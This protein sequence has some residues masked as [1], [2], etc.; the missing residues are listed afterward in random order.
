M[1]NAIV[2]WLASA[3]MVWGQVSYNFSNFAGQH[4]SAGSADGTGSEAKF[5]YPQGVAVDNAGNVYVGDS[6]NHTI[7]KVNPKGVV[8]T[9]AGS[10]GI[11]GSAD[12]TGRAARFNYADGVAVDSAGIVYVAD[13]NNCTIRIVSLAGVVT[14]LAGLA[15]SSGSADGIGGSARFNFPN[16]VAVDGAGNVFVADSGNQ[17]IRK[18]TPMGV[19]TTLA[20]SPGI[21]GSADGTGR[22]ALFNDPWGVAVD[23]AGNV[24]VAD[25]SNHTIRK[26]TPMGVVTTFA[27]RPGVVGYADGMGSAARFSQP[28]GVAVDSVGN[29]FVADSFNGMI[30]KVTPIGVVTTLAGTSVGLNY[31][32]SLAVDG[33]GNLYVADFHNN[34][35][36]K[37]TPLSFTVSIGWNNG[38]PQLEIIGTLGKSYTLEY[39]PTMP[40]DNNWQVL[41]NLTLTTSPLY[42]IDS[43]SNSATQRFYRLREEAVLPLIAPTITTQPISQTAAENAK[44]SF[45]VVAD[46]T[47]PLNYQ[48]MFNG[49]NISGANNNQ[50]TINNVQA[51]NAGNYTVIV[52][53][54][55]GFSISQPATLTVNEA[56]LAPDSIAGRT[57]TCS[58][59]SGSAPFA[60]SGS[61]KIV[62]SSSG[63]TYLIVP[64]YG[65]IVSSSGTYTY[66]KTSATSAVLIL[67]DSRVGSLVTTVTFIN[68]TGGTYVNTSSAFGVIQSGN[69]SMN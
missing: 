65:N 12:G 20:G 39:A 21:I 22:T 3:L 9:L 43:S 64:I 14:T 5:F 15:G 53:N 23:N 4:G 2:L 30:R 51:A 36:I 54:G 55:G 33:T 66:T 29:V 34:R 27:G 67:N 69:F 63:N 17:T 57:F 25:E 7:R 37:G 48:W 1:K 6:F 61:Y 19:V 42:F 41:T 44:V 16:S 8:T 26:V 32:P 40:P 11:I 52:S 10:P 13:R 47:T 49:V 28:H 58:I 59:T 56:S 60:T 38:K 24:F 35:I 68:T 50:L 46:G 45:S 18:V 62:V 31:P